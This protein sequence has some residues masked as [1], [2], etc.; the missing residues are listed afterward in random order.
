VEKTVTDTRIDWEAL[1][2][3]AYA[4]NREVALQWAKEDQEAEDADNA[5]SDRS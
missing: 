5:D 2:A 4:A 3:K 1:K